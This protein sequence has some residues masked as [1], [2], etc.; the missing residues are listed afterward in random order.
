MSLKNT[1]AVT[2]L[3]TAAFVTAAHA[4]TTGAATGTVK[5]DPAQTAA[6]QANGIPQYDFRTKDGNNPAKSIADTEKQ[7]RKDSRIAIMVDGD[8]ALYAALQNAVK[9]AP[10]NARVLLARGDKNP[11]KTTYIHVYG[12]SPDGGT[13]R[14]FKMDGYT[15]AMFEDGAEGHKLLTGWLTRVYNKVSPTWPK[16]PAANTPAAR[17]LEP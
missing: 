8:D 12:G 15:A 14:G 16:T 1:L 7:A 4:Q 6:Q 17:L 2:L 3:T 9:D 5:K 13:I 11:G 10:W